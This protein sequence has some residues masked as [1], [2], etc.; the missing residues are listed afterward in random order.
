MAWHDQD[1]WLTAALS[2]NLSTI[3]I[4]LAVA[5][6]LPVLLHSFLYRKVGA[7]QNQPAFLLLGPSGAGKTAFTTLTERNTTPATHTSTTPLTVSALLPAPHVPASSH[8]RSPGDP[9]YERSRRFLLL[10]TPGHGKLRHFA[11]AQLSEP[12]IKSI[13]AIIFVVD[14]A[15]L[16]EEAGLVEAAEYLHD[17]LLALQKR[18]T[19]ARSSKGP[20]EIPV[21]V[22]ANKMD[23]FTALPPSL[24]KMQLEKAISEVRRSRAKALRDAG[25]VL[26]GREDG[27]ADEEKEWLGEGGDGD[28]EFGM[29]GESGVGVEVLGGNVVGKEGEGVAAWW[30]WIAEH[31]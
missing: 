29:M 20:A 16:A 3:L 19:G 2:P 9:A 28:F 1:S 12:K 31:L 24:V 7:V 6:I 25:T 21:L 22:A 8:Y 23:L 14:A 15:A 17:V 5:L 4:T 30:A 13:K 26:D 18:Y 11:A 27:E 10:D